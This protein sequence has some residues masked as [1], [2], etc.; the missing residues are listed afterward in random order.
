MCIFDYY[1]MNLRIRNMAWRKNIFICT[2]ALIWL[3]S[4][5]M[6]RAAYQQSPT[7]E[8]FGLKY[9]RNLTNGIQGI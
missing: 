6:Q 9:T 2:A 1:G 3:V 8:F 4:I 5:S 7:V